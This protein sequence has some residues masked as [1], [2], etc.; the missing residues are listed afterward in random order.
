VD[1]ATIMVPMGRTEA[2]PDELELVSTFARQLGARILGVMARE[3]SPALYY[4]AGVVA[5]DIVEEDRKRLGEILAKAEK[6]FRSV[7]GTQ[8]PSVEW[9]SNIDWPTDFALCEARSADLI[10]SFK[11]PIQ[12][13][14]DLEVGTL[15]LKAGRPVLLLSET[16]LAMPP[17]VLVTWKDTREARRAVRDALPFLRR[18]S[19]V[20]VIEIVE[21]DWSQ[22]A[23]ES[24]LKD[25]VAWLATHDINATS[26]THGSTANVAEQVDAAARELGAD[27][28]VA[29]GYG[30]TRLGEWVF[31]G[32]THHLITRSECSVMLSH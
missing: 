8:H 24:H 10:V 18:G 22:S 19:S 5:G 13:N 16:G 2:S 30:H 11:R 31:G 25:V 20:H 12:A 21:G 9:R 32:M 27:L 6:R 28:I 7:I 29:G 26:A 23:A 14:D 17:K 4:E 3:L 1:I 15:V